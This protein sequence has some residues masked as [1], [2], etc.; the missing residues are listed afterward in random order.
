VPAFN[1][2]QINK[3]VA[4]SEGDE[5]MLYILLATTGRRIGEYLGLEVR[6]ILNGG[7]TLRIEQAVNRFGE[8]AG[9][10]T[11]AAKRNVDVSSDMVVLTNEFIIGK[12]GLLC[13]RRATAHH[14]LQ[15][16]CE[17]AGCKSD[18]QITDSTLS[19]DTA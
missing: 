16:I 11:R 14:I 19:E 12:S 17:V 4:D 3:L 2:E 5:R 8:L 18:S 1:A 13:L 9:L 7:R 15:A 6:H 10:K